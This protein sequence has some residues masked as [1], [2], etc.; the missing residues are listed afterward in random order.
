MAAAGL[1]NRDIGELVDL[2]YNQVGMW[3][4]RY[5]EFGLAGL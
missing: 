5:A 1:T 2:H 4:Q 3:R